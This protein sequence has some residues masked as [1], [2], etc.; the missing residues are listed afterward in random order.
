MTLTKN[1]SL[2]TDGKIPKHT[3][4]PFDNTC[5]IAL[6]GSCDHLGIEHARV[7][8]CGIARA[9]D[10]IQRNNQDIQK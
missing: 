8:S 10:I 1:K 6:N 9:F 5:D 3:M 4:C 7:F 2:L